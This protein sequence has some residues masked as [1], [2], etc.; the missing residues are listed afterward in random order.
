MARKPTRRSRRAP[1]PPVLQRL[2]TNFL[3]GL[4]VVLPMFLTAYILIWFVGFVDDKVVP[5]IPRAYDPEN[6][7]GRNI[8]GFGL[9]LFIAFTTLVGALAK[10]LIGRSILQFGESVLGRT[11]IVRPIYNALKQIAETLFT[12]SGNTFQRGLPGRVPAQGRLVGRLHVHPGAP[13][14]PGAH[15]RGR[16]GVG[17][18]ADDAEPDH[19][20]PALRAAR[21]RSCRST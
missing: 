18:R 8:F 9:V 1:R 4:V 15:R 14:D 6:I 2:R 5:L 21:P 13:R 19:R 20:L 17:L 16:P 12:E 10:N 11:P 7:F 3:T